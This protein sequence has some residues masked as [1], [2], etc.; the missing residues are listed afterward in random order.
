MYSDHNYTGDADSV[1]EELLAGVPELEEKGQVV[2]QAVEEGYFSL[3]QALSIYKLSE[4]EY[5]TYLLLKNRGKLESAP[6]QSQVFSVVAFIVRSFHG[7]SSEF[8]PT[9]K[10]VMQNLET[11][12]KDSPLSEMYAR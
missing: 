7:A 12:T 8:D 9:G 1:G 4:V 11:L 2:D 3:D 6:K 5:M 10:K